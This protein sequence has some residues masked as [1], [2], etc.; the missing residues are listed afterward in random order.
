MMTG[1]EL[2]ENIVL[3]RDTQ[4][5]WKENYRK[6]TIERKTIIKRHGYYDQCEKVE[7]ASTDNE[8]KA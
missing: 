1:F 5:H 6:I 2:I 3:Q 7:F 4:V 8:E